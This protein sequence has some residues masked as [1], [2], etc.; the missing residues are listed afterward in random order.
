MDAWSIIK[1]MNSE[2]PT[3]PG[4]A[5]KAINK[6]FSDQQIDRYKKEFKDKTEDSGTLLDDAEELN[7]P[8]DLDER[9]TERLDEITEQDTIDRDKTNKNAFGEGVKLLTNKLRTLSANNL[10]SGYNRDLALEEFS[11]LEGEVG[12]VRTLLDKSKK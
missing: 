9:G 5:Y 2:S 7:I 3:I 11:K 1:N 10:R 6:L 4:Q 8:S 12:R